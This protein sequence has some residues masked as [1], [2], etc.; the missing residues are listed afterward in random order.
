MFRIL[1]MSAPACL[2]FLFIFEVL[3]LFA[4][5]HAGLT[6]TWVEFDF[7]VGQFLQN[8]PKA[9]LF[10][11]ITCLFMF[12]F[13][14]YSR[15]AVVSA[16]VAIPRLL[17]AFAA[18]LLLLALV[19]YSLPASIIW[20]SVLV[21]AMLIAFIGI[22]ITRRFGRH[23]FD[24]HLLKRR[25]AVLG[26]GLQAA[27]IEALSEEAF[28]SFTCVGYLPIDGEVVEVPRA[29]LL[30]PT[31]DTAELLRHRRVEEIVIATNCRNDLPTRAVVDCRLSGIKISDYET[32]YGHETGR[33]DLDFLAPDWFFVEDG[34]HAARL[35]RWGKRTLDVVLSGILLLIMAPLFAIIALAI[36][37]EDGGPV[38][39]SQ[40][41]VGR[42]GKIFQLTKFRSMRKDAESDGVPRWAVQRDSR[43]TRVGWIL[44]ASHL[45]EVPQLWRILKGDMSFVGPR[46]ERPFF[47]R[48][49]AEAHP[50]YQDR[51]AIK[52]GL[53][54]WAQINFPYART[55]AEARRKLEYDLYYVRYGNTLLD[56]VILLQTMRVVLWPSA[57]H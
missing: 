22:F 28:A 51:H 9:L 16:S 30:G 15:E 29:R 54:G 33:I 27:R 43:V 46:P 20:R 34:F 5:F 37:L 14:L 50:Y 10:V 7:S 2:V 13:G 40:E 47:V 18:A 45:D 11:G 26:A 12:A 8:L 39:Y 55:P 48:Q 23:F 49:L 25:L 3:L 19:F 4:A 53:T 38:F 36:K 35:D 41:R 6:F 17:A 56:A 24:S 52:P 1:R 44:R 42:G 31:N 21:Q 57:A 32:F